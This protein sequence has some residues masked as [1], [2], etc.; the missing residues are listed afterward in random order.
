MSLSEI[1]VSV[2]NKCGFYVDIY[3]S[4]VLC[5]FWLKIVSLF[6]CLIG[7][8]C[9]IAESCGPVIIYR[10]ACNMRLGGQLVKALGL[11]VG[12]YGLKAIVII[13]KHF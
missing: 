13:I 7:T 11:L 3:C 6:C 10:V 8:I 2:R 5:K 9:R 1:M 12:K 4:S